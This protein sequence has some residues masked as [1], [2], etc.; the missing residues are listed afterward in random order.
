MSSNS[1]GCVNNTIRLRSG[2]YFDLADP[3]PEQ[4]T[5]ADIA[6]ALSKEQ[7]PIPIGGKLTGVPWAH[8]VRLVDVFAIWMAR[9]LPFEGK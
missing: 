2:L 8:V 9:D 6:G 1:F 3:K 4:F 7:L 5:F